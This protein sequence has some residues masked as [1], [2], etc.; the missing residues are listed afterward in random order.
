MQDSEDV[1]TETRNH[2]G[3]LVFVEKRDPT[4]LGDSVVSLG[5]IVMYHCK[6]DKKSTSSCPLCRTHHLEER[7][8]NL[9]LSIM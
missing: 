8:I 2:N 4:P 3:I 5:K 9:K 6:N 1:L 7:Q